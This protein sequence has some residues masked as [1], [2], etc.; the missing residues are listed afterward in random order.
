MIAKM[1]QSIE[2]S[3]KRKPTSGSKST[4]YLNWVSSPANYLLYSSYSSTQ[5][6]AGNPLF[7]PNRDT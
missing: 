2:K 7:C 1:P 6:Q 3:A 5:P 4:Q